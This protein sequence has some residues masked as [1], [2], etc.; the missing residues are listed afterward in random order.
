M[1]STLR[2]LL[3]LADAPRGR[4]VLAVT[5]GATTVLFGAGL[6]ATAGYYE[7]TRFRRSGP[8]NVRPPDSPSRHF[9]AILT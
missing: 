3:V 8:R 4:L 7:V 9:R 5:L 2:R 1:T 6:M